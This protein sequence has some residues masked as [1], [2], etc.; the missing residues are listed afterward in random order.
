[1]PS[2]LALTAF[3]LTTFLAFL[4]ARRP[5]PIHP[6]GLRATTRRVDASR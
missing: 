6:S 3:C 5:Q 1:M 2:L 4:A